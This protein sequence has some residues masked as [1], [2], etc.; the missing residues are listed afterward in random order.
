MREEKRPATGRNV[1]D[2]ENNGNF[3]STTLRRCVC[4]RTAYTANLPLLTCQTEKMTGGS[5]VLES[6]TQWEEEILQEQM[7]FCKNQK[8]KKKT[9][10]EP[11]SP[12]DAHKRAAEIL[13]KGWGDEM[14]SGTLMTQGGV[15]TKGN[16]STTPAM[17][18]A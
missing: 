2:L 7:T 6:S 18:V 16:V 5:N 1:G 11:Y 12:A 10:N 8:K 14:Q 4:P 15:Q 13:T 3:P 9:H 17:M